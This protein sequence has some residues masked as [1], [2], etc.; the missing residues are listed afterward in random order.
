MTDRIPEALS[1]YVNALRDHD[2]DGVANTV[3]DNVLFISATRFLDKSQFLAMLRALYTAFPDWKYEHDCIE[4][5]GEGNYAIKW[6]QSGTHTGIWTMP[7]MKP[8]APTGKRVQIVPHYFFYR[9][10]GGLL[11]LI[12]PEPVLGGAPRGILEQIGVD[13][14][15]L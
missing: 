12:F 15:D 5:R 6:R 11:V 14:P 8:I 7:G 4:V 13:S 9:I 1:S 10:A 2:V 3:A